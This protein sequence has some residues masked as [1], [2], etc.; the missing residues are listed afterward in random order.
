MGSLVKVKGYWDGARVKVGAAMETRDGAA[1]A[2][3]RAS[4]PGNDAGAGYAGASAGL[5]VAAD[6]VATAI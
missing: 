4:E 6:N 3:V 2:V 5:T 1:A